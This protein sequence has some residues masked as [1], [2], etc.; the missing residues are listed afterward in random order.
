MYSTSDFQHSFFEGR[1]C[2][3]FGFGVTAC[4]M[5]NHNVDTWKESVGLDN[6][7]ELNSGETF[8]F[9]GTCVGRKA[10]AE[11]SPGLAST[12]MASL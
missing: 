1:I 11:Y 5:V 3:A 2:Y 6:V 8:L 4:I 10:Y 12:L 9:K 7:S